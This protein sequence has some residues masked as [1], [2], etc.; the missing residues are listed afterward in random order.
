MNDVERGTYRLTDAEVQEI[1]DVKKA[2]LKGCET[3]VIA[4]CARRTEGAGLTWV[5]EWTCAYAQW[6]GTVTRRLFLTWAVKTRKG[7]RC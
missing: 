6:T 5:K 7:G 1:L 4:H 2:D 3:D